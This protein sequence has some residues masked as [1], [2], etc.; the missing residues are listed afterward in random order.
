MTILEEIQSIIDDDTEALNA[1]RIHKRKALFRRV[2]ETRRKGVDIP[3][4]ELKKKIQ[5]YVEEDHCYQ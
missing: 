4:M 3:L 1:L 2:I 5:R